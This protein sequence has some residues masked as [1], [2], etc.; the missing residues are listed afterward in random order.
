M[1]VLFIAY[2]FPPFGGAGAQRSAK[3]VR[4]LPEHGVQPLVVTRP[5]S[6]ESR[7]SPVDVSQEAD[8]PVG[9]SIYR[10]S[11]PGPP[12]PSPLRGRLERWIRA[13][14][15]FASWWSEC[16]IKA[17]LRAAS[18][19]SIDLIYVSMD[20]F[21]G[22][23]PARWL[24]Q[25]LGIPWVADLRDPWALDEMRVFPSRLHRALETNRMRSA[26]RSA[27]LVIMNTPRASRAVREQLF[28]P[29]CPPVVTLTNGF[30]ASDFA[31]LAPQRTDR[32]FRIVPTG[33]LQ[34]ALGLRHRRSRLWR[35]IFG[36]ERV[37]VDILTRSHVVLLRALEIWSE[38]HPTEARS[39]RLLLAGPLT[40]ADKRAIEQS[41]VRD[42]VR[43][44]GLVPHKQSV[45]LL[46]SADA[47]FLPMQRLERGESFIVPGKTYEYMA[48]GPPILAAVPEGDT[49]DL[50]RRNSEAQ[51]VDPGD[52]HAMVD[53]LRWL[54]YK[55]ACTSERQDER[56]ARLKRF[57]R[58]T[59]AQNLSLWFHEIAKGEQP[60]DDGALAGG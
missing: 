17:G 30:D 57:D 47:L 4:Y 8:V 53:A 54:R 46:R 25:R 40:S 26:L 55:R 29:P 38:K 2:H 20:P 1:K 36:G 60:T 22:A 45:D 16:C 39:V 59:L 10:G 52:A 44:E 9:T 37:P 13:R 41:K 15:Q 6:A 56:L 14:S 11:L 3:L 43:V 58:R 49:R 12:R 31:G 18:E 19:H 5:L 48:A 27:D 24:A 28:R 33:Y 23:D 50:L 34:T 7:W 21:E 42:L 35:R 32:W 51:I